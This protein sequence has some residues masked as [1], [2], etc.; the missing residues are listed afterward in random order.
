MSNESTTRS[1]PRRYIILIVLKPHRK[2]IRIMSSMQRLVLKV[3]NSLGNALYK[4]VHT[5]TNLIKTFSSFSPPLSLHPP[6]IPPRSIPVF[7]F[8]FYSAPKLELH[9]PSAA[10]PLGPGPALPRCKVEMLMLIKSFIWFRLISVALLLS[11]A[12]ANQIRPSGGPRRAD[13]YGRSS[14]WSPAAV[15]L[16]KRRMRRRRRFCA[17]LLFFF[18]FF[19]PLF[20]FSIQFIS[21]LFNWCDSKQTCL[22]GLLLLYQW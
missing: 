21:N 7:F 11:W 16:L 12:A 13:G 8:F 18:F 9:Y 17:L 1:T 14:L 22:Q 15:C 10:Q 2:P 20:V 3:W 19:V 6:L 4:T 5:R